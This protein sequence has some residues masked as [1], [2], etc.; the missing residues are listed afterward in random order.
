M[1]P[2]IPV[3]ARVDGRAF[4]Q[5]TK[6]LDRPYDDRMVDLMIEVTKY[7]VEETNARC[8]YTQSDEISLVWLSEHPD[9]EMFFGGKMSKMVSVVGSLATLAF[10]RL[11]PHRI[12]THEHKMPVFDNRFWEVPVE[13]EAANYFIW[14]EQDAT[15]NSVSM[16]ARCCYSHQELHGKSCSEMQEMLFQKGAN[17]NNYP[18]HFKRGTYVRRRTLERTLTN[19][20]LADLPPKHHAHENPDLV[21]KRSIVVVEDFEPLTRMVNREA[22]ILHGAEPE[23][24]S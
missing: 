8:G 22:V 10:N 13:Y 3:L 7:L 11:L 15:R 17:W 20:E 19:Q 4:S 2:M 23:Y 9:S 1:M 14:R 18:R 6:D 16:A 24:G 21:V 12:P 5:F